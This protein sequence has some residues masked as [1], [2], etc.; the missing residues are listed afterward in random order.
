MKRKLLAALLCGAMMTTCALPAQAVFAEEPA[1]NED[2]VQEQETVAASGN[3]L[4]WDDAQK[5]LVQEEIPADAKNITDALHE[6]NTTIPSGVY[7]VSGEVVAAD[8]I[9]I[10]GNVTLIL[11]DGCTLDASNGGV[12]VAEGNAVT[13]TAQ[14]SGDKQG[15]LIAKCTNEMNDD[16]VGN[17]CA[18]IG[19]NSD[20]SAGTITISGGKIDALVQSDSGDNSAAAIGGGFDGSG[21]T[22]TINGGDVT[23]TSEIQTGYGSNSGAAIGGGMYG[24]SGTITINGGKVTATAQTMTTSNNSA[25]IGGGDSGNSGIIIINEGIVTATSQGKEATN[26]AGIGGGRGGVRGSIEI[27]GGIVAAFSKKIGDGGLSVYA[28]AIGGGGNGGAVDSITISGG[29]VTASVSDRANEKVHDIGGVAQAGRITTGGDGHAVI[30]A[31]SIEDTTDAADWHGIFFIG[32][33]GRVYGQNVQPTEDWSV[34]AGKSLTIGDTQTVIIP[35]DVTL[36]N[37]EG[38]TLN[39]NGTIINHGTITP[40][41]G[42]YGKVLIGEKRPAATIDF[43]QEQLSGFESGKTYKINDKSVEASGSTLEIKEEWM[44]KSLSII[45][46]ATA[47]NHV[48]SLP[49]ELKIPARP[50]APAELTP[51]NETTAGKNDGQITG[52]NAT[53]EY[54]L[55]KEGEVWNECKGTAITNLA[56]GTYE[57]RFSAK[58]DAFTSEVKEVTIAE[59]DVLVEKPVLNIGAH[60]TATVNPQQTTAGATVTITT[61]PENGYEVDGVT[62]ATKDGAAVEVKTNAD[63]TY[64]FTQPAIQAIVTVTFKE[65]AITPEPTPEPEPTPDPVPP[66]PPTYRPDISE[67]E[68]GTTSVTPKRPEKGDEVT[69]TPTPEDGYEVDKVVV[70][71]KKGNELDV[72]KNDDG[73]F[74]FTQPAGRVTITVTYK[75]IEEPKQNVSDIFIDVAPDAWYVDAVQFAYDEGIMTGTSAT[76]FSPALTTTRG[77]IVAILHRLEGSPTVSGE[78]FTDVAAGDWYAEAVNWAASEGIVNGVSATTFVPNAPI[79]R[80]QLA[81]ILYNYAEYKGMDTSARADLSV[82]SDAS[83]VSAWAENVISWANAE[84]FV[85]GVTNTTLVPQGQ[86]TRGQVAAIFQR[87]LSK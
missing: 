36:T 84:G 71:D 7:A 10:Q 58:Q 15:K 27:N 85:N 80:E 53:M 34:P 46:L 68:G 38:A 13:I 56:P 70:T 74:T 66:T 2:V 73:T 16:G 5:Q 86:A 72:T 82:Y 12:Q 41:E 26:G 20:Q 22:I 33:E 39:N 14:S 23:A 32:N 62:V 48:D 30:I 55:K 47:E 49:Q 44:G 51:V 19:G 28:A 29:T 60:G 37:E 63:G 75:K 17:Q 43:A 54:R 57:V 3:Y 24:S 42:N 18:A 9:V 4:V 79:T 50:A 76:T 8:R 45:K 67:S 81:A 1:Q 25:A 11:M 21:G 65:K 31:E 6:E 83:S 59:G 35:D 78:R 64:S 87:F 61:Q 77:M 40:E 52:V 69:I